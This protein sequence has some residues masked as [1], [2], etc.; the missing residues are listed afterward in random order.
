MVIYNDIVPFKKYAHASG[1]DIFAGCS[2]VQVHFTNIHPVYFTG[3]FLLTY[4]KT[5][6]IGRTKSPNLNV[7]CLALQLSLLNPMKM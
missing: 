2:Q 4:R 5:P 1:F 6:S 3:I 7:S